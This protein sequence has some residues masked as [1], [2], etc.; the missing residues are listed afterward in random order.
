M[1][2][3][4]CLSDELNFIFLHTI[5]RPNNEANKNRTELIHA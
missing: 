1:P 5:H 2:D 3:V 4:D